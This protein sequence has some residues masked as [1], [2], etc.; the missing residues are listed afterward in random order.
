DAADPATVA[1]DPSDP[2]DP[3]AG[4]S[5]AAAVGAAAKTMVSARIG[6]V[7]AAK[8]VGRRRGGR[9]AEFS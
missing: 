9:T 1:D 6:A 7:I 5:S 8:D 4:R 3:E 2:E